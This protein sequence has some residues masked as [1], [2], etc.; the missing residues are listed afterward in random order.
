MIAK[1]CLLE[2]HSMSSSFGG[3]EDDDGGHRA[4]RAQRPRRPRASIGHVPA[5][6]DV[7]SKLPMGPQSLAEFLNHP[8]D[9]WSNLKNGFD[10]T[11]RFQQASISI[12]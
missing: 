12:G 6:A 8:L 7:P 5:V 10:G 3:I 9:A 4:M 1:R 11:K 2:D